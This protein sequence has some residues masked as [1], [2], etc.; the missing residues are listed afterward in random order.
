MNTSLTCTF[1]IHYSRAGFE[2]VL[3]LYIVHTLQQYGFWI[4][5]G[6]VHCS[7]TTAVRVLNTSWTCTL[8]IQY[9]STGFEY[10]L[11]LYIVHTLQQCGFWIRPWPVHC[12][13]TT[14]VRVLNTSLTCTLLIHYSSAGFGYVLDL[15]IAHILQQCGF[16][17]RPWPVHCSY[18]IAVRVLDTSLTCTLLIHYSSAGFGYVLDLY[19]AHTLQQSGFWIRP[20]PVHCSYTTAVRVLDTSLTCT[21]FIHYSSA[22]FGYV[23]DLY[24]AHTLQQ[25]GFW[26]RHWPVHC[27]YTTA[28]RVLNT[29]LTCTLFIHYS[30]AGFEYVLDLYIVHTLQ[31]CGFWIRPGHVHC[32]YTTVVWVLNTYVLDLY[33]VHTLQQ[34]GFWIRPGPVHCSYT[35]AVRVLNTSL[36]CTLFIHYSSTGFEYVLD[37]YIV[38]TQQQCGFWIRPG[39]VHCSYTTAVRG[40]NTSWTCTL[41]IHYSSAGFEYVLDLYIVHT[42]Q[43]YGFWIRPWL[44][45]CSHTTAVRVLNTSLTC[46]LFIHY[47]S[48]GFEYV[49]DLYIVHTL[50]Q[51]GF[52]IRP[53]PVHCSYTTEVW[54]LNTSLTCT[55]FIHYR[56]MGFEY[57]LDL[58][59]VHTLQQYGFWIR[60]GPVHCSYNTA[61]RV[62]N[63]SL[64]CTLFIHYSC[65]GFGYV[66]DLYIV[67]T[68]QLCGF[69]ICPWHVLCS[70]TTAVRLLNTSLTCTL[71]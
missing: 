68:L 38:H 19:I 52:W 69:W 25:S 11:D 7:Y 66:L 28:V 61:V 39:P 40:L 10:V 56:S 48:T 54:V 24:I 34:Y 45:H 41:F 44:V 23:L 55:L 57:V 51:C 49:L 63:T 36:T 5:P 43:Q 13:Y 9:S 59:I 4:R 2:Y 67:H 29:S 50:Q 71:S 20:W 15:Y 31:Q 47:S 37:L 22:G 26:I 64:T 17:I 8:F 32:P 18:T 14:A 21:L 60:P 33:I 16:W 6:P 53:G 58:Y 46:T 12:S 1:F 42:I 65:A 3:D 70:Y 30:S 62:L 27:S 35:T